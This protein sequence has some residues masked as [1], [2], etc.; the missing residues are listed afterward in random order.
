M[1]PDPKFVRAFLLTYRSFCTLQELL[2]LLVLL[3]CYLT[4][5]EGARVQGG[6]G[7]GGFVGCFMSQHHASVFQ[8][9]ICSDNCTCCHTE[10]EV[11]EHCFC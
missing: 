2:Q 10:I 1:Y 5:R 3:V 9:W 7:G 11:A 8:G 6:E 4:S